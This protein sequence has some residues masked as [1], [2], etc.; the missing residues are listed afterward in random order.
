MTTMTT[1]TANRHAVARSRPWIRKQW[2]HEKSRLLRVLDRY[3]AEFRAG[4][5][6]QPITTP[7][8]SALAG[9]R[10][11]VPAEEWRET[12][13][14]DLRPHP[15]IPL[16]HQDPYS[17][18]GFRKPR[19]YPGDAVLL[20]FMYGGGASSEL[21]KAASHVGAVLYDECRRHPSFAAVRGRR[22]YLAQRLGALCESGRPHILS[23]ACGHMREAAMLD[24]AN[25]ATR[26][27][28]FVALD[29]DA[30]TLQVVR[31]DHAVLSPEP[32]QAS[33]L[34]LL[35]SGHEIGTFDFI[36]SAGLYDYLSDD[37][38]RRL[39]VR[40]AGM[41]KPNGC[42][43]VANMLPNLPAA[44]Y[45]E[46]VMDWWL[47]YRTIRQLRSVSGDVRAATVI[48]HR[49]PHVGYIEIVNGK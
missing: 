40:L 25:A 48:A 14:R 49:R 31:A 16:L 47:I 27:G 42:L 23:V 38:A 20:D 7:V 3:A 29:Q 21:V 37:V 33:V 15:I 10:N 8:A 4:C 26:P 2:G 28:R 46:T 18:Y 43:L 34:A 11:R 24:A 17:S 30:V 44:G 13:A 9:Y 32:V 22:D 39:T 35:R 41:L 6:S 19:G 36:Y 1:R 45:M 5:I 12:V